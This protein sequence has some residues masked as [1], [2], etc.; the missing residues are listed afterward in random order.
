MVAVGA[1]KDLGLDTHGT[2]RS[3]RV[4]QERVRRAAQ[5]AKGIRAVLQADK[6]ARAL[7]GTAFKPAALWGLE[8][9][10]LA[11]TTLKKLKALVVGMSTAKYP[12]GC[13]TSAIRI[14]LGEAADPALHGR[15]Q[16][17]REWLHVGSELE[18]GQKDALNL[19]WSR[20][21]GVIRRSPRPW[22]QVK[23][24]ISATI[25][26]LLARPFKTESL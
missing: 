3:T 24:T 5:R 21:V 22:A 25:A 16:L 15:L 8:G 20:L 26:A 14:G 13:A 4:Q 11:P 12:G 9:P 7:V 18:E 1:G 6:G 2:R 19:A 17:F 23:G 10:G